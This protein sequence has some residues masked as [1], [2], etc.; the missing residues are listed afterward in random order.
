MCP[1][2]Q[3]KKKVLKI[4][5]NLL[6]W[7]QINPFPSVHVPLIYLC[8]HHFHQK[9]HMREI[10]LRRAGSVFWLGALIIDGM[11]CTSLYGCDN[12]TSDYADPL[13]HIH[14]PPRRRGGAWEQTQQ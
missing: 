8:P 6:Q 7:C 14:E 11:Y 3:K 5:V 13:I 4:S 2:A 1:N 12:A 10:K 9:R